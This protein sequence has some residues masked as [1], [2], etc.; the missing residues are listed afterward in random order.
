VPD[1]I[2]VTIGY[3]VHHD[4]LEMDFFLIQLPRQARSI[5]TLT[6]CYSLIFNANAFGENN[7]AKA[8]DSYYNALFQGSMPT[9]PSIQ[10]GTGPQA[11]LIKKGEYLAIVGDCISCHSKQGRAA[12]SGGLAMETPFGTIFTPNITP[13]KTTGIGNWTQAQFIKAMHEGMSPNGKYYYPAFP[14][15][16]FH[17]VTQEDLVALKAYLDAIP[18]VVANNKPPKMKFLLG[19]RF[20]QL[21]WRL[22]FFRDDSYFKPDPKQSPLWNRGKYLVEG[23]GHCGMCHTPMYYLVSKNLVLGAPIKKYNLAGAFVQGFYAP[24]ITKTNL[25]NVSMQGLADVFLNARMIGGGYVQG[26]MAEAVHYSLSRLTVEDVQAI[27]TYLKS[28]KSETTPIPESGST[29]KIGEAVYKQHCKVCHT[30]HV[31]EAPQFGNQADWVGILEKKGLNQLYANVINGIGDMPPRGTCLSC[32]TE[33]LQAAVLYIIANSVPRTGHVLGAEKT[34]IKATEEATAPPLSL[35]EGQQIYLRYCDQCHNGSFAGA[36]KLGDKA[37]WEPLIDRG[38]PRLLA[39][40]LYGHHNMPAYGGCQDCTQT[41]MLEALIYMV[42]MSK[43]SGN[44]LLWLGDNAVVKGASSKVNTIQ[45]I[46]ANTFLMKGANVYKD[47][48]AKCHGSNGQ[49]VPHESP[50]LAGSSVTIGPPLDTIQIV[51]NGVSDTNMKPFKDQLTVEQ[52][53]AVISYIRNAW[54]NNDKTKFGKYAGGITLPSTI[55]RSLGKQQQPNS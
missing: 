54:G 55:E 22:L 21:G 44:Y 1:Q 50:A 24:D 15:I 46:D 25:K 14:Y 19:W 41:Q 32:S 27:A 11:E 34:A 13:D 2:R 35:Q 16:Y 12:F 31:A 52:L 17:Y 7:A 9:Y 37:A 48:C 45:N 33:Q 36:P 10:Y 39:Q 51:L 20:L 38:I 23:L 30:S 5:I 26:P 28:V 3:F 6:M 40:T 43:S 18:P 4:A 53:A 42:Q 8:P 49:G 29:L 47:F